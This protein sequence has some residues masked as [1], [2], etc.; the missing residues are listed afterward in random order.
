[1]DLR[2]TVVPP[3]SRETS[4]IGDGEAMSI[5]CPVTQTICRNVST[6]R[7]KGRVTDKSRPAAARETT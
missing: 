5:G 4:R 6:G 1:M 3:V 2:W 7:S